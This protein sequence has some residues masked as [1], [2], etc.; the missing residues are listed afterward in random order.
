[1][2]LFSGEA[3]K[4]KSKPKPNPLD[5]EDAYLRLKASIANGKMKPLEVTGI[6]IDQKDGARLGLKFPARTATD[7]LRRFVKALG[8]EAEYHIV[9]YE[10]DTPGLWAVTVTYEPPARHSQK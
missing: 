4:R 7:Q 8:L 3:P 5:R 9:K 2:K 1:M 10:T 6:M